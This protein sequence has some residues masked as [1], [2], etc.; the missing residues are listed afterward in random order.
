MS[1]EEIRDNLNIGLTLAEQHP[2]GMPLD[3]LLI[4]TL[5]YT[6]GASWPMGDRDHYISRLRRAENIGLHNY[7][8]RLPG[9]FTINAQPFGNIFVYKA[10]WYTW[11][12]PA[13]NTT[14]TVLVCHKDLVPMRRWRD[15]YLETRV[16]TTRS[17]RTADNLVRQEKALARQDMQEVRNIQAGMVQDGTLSEVVTGLLGVPYV[18]VSSMLNLLSQ[19][20]P[21][22]P[23]QFN[24]TRQAQRIRQ[25]ENR[26][27]DE[28]AAIVR[29]LSNLITIRQD[30][31]RNA[32]QLALQDARDRLNNLN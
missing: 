16:G 3:D 32:R 19:G 13:T 15:S 2:Y 23:A 24:F 1:V 30:L 31:P 9:Y 18:D 8:L 6:P 26:L 7:A 29:S 21:Y 4:Q 22:G 14:C 25:L 28:Q 5:G 12:N 17:V 11:V 10:V 27:A 20:N